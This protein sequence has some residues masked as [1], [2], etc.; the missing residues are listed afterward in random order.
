MTAVCIAGLHRSGTSMVAR[1]LARA[2]VY[3]GPEE[4]LLAPAADNPEGFWENR[5]FLQVNDALLDRF[6]GAWDVVPSFPEQWW[7]RP[8]LDDLRARAR[9]LVERFDGHEGWGWKDP[10]NSLTLPFWHSMVPDL[11]VVVCVRNP[12]EIARSFTRRGYTSTRFS[13]D[14]WV[15][16]TDRLLAAVELGDCVVTHYASYFHDPERE[17]RRVADALE[18]DASESV[19]RRAREDAVV[20][21]LRHNRV[22]LHDLTAALPAEVATRYERLCAASGPVFAASQRTEDGAAKTAP[23]V[24]PGT[25]GA[26]DP[27][28]AELAEA[29]ELVENLVLQVEGLNRELA[30]LRGSRTFRCAAGLRGLSAGL[31]RR[32][33]PGERSAD[34]SSLR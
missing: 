12:L 3:L 25:V 15:A 16:Y 14:L 34:A 30:L 1:L 9:D 26:Q 18:L 6:G 4:E 22:R 13:L 29:R 8:E 21:S 11:K 17:L 24:E 31:R 23:S 33:V 5:E 28:D 20:P 7:A 10:R 27:L 2:G 19:L 32:G